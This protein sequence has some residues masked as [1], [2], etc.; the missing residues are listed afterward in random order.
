MI[1]FFFDKNRYEIENNEFEI[2]SQSNEQIENWFCDKLF[3]TAN[4]YNDELTFRRN[5]R[6]MSVL[7]IEKVVQSVGKC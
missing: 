4:Q 7:R 2:F 5:I 6:S 3:L 1:D